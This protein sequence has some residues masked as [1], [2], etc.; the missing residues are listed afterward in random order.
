[1]LTLFRNR[2]IA[3]YIGVFFFSILVHLPGFLLPRNVLQESFFL[4]E[5]ILKSFSISYPW[6][7]FGLAYVF[8]LIVTIALIQLLKKVKLF[9][10]KSLLIPY[11]FL[12]FCG[13]SFSMMQFSEFHLILIAKITLIYI[14]FALDEMPRDKIPLNLFALGFMTGC[15]MLIDPYNLLYLVVIV[16]GVLLFKPSQAKDI[17]VFILGFVIVI[18]FIFSIYFIMDLKEGITSFFAT[19]IHLSS[20][21]LFYPFQPIYFLFFFLL[22]GMIQ[23]YSR[24]GRN[25]IFTRKCHQFFVVMLAVNIILTLVNGK[26]LIENTQNFGIL[27]AVYVGN[28]LF[29]REKKWIPEVINGVLIVLMIWYQYDY[30][31][32]IKFE[33][34]PEYLFINSI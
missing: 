7:S 27:F 32:P 9:E 12:M 23:V 14:V 5:S 11:A 16:F 17:L 10:N 21:S 2:D 25:V 34:I 33:Q 15:L 6:L 24:Y 19:S 3:S 29:A 4:Q 1:M 28:L 30:Y 13:F 26:T 18:F 20:R 22:I 31:L 8:N